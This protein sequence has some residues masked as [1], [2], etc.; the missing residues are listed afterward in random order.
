M[1]SGQ[2]TALLYVSLPTLHKLQTS[3]ALSF[4]RDLNVNLHFTKIK[5]TF[6]LRVIAPNGTEKYLREWYDL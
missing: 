5:T 6:I 4:P 2:S 1:W 3:D